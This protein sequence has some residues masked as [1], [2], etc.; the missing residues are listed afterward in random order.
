MH[1]LCTCLTQ[2]EHVMNEKRILQMCYH[3]FIMRLIG[4]FQDDRELYMLLELSLG[5]ELFSLLR[6]VGSLHETSARFY[7]ACVCSAFVYLH[8]KKIVYRDLKP[9][10]LIFNA[11]GYIVVVDFGF[12]KHVPTRTWTLCGT[13]EYLP[14]EMLLQKGSTLS[15]DWW[16]FG[17]LIYE[18]TFGQP[19][20][21]S[22]EGDQ[23]EIY[24]QILENSPK[25]PRS[26]FSPAAKELISKLLVSEP[27]K[28][29]GSAKLGTRAISTHEYFGAINWEK[30]TSKELAAP[31]VPKIASPFDTSNFDDYGDEDVAAGEDPNDFIDPTGHQRLFE[32]WD[33]IKA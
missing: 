24:Q 30:L 13:P 17:V 23:M 25:Y 4:A 27:A 22:P 16:S 26:R 20:F 29:L 31:Y 21:Y 8:D 15:A 6:K 5:G 12:A 28:R 2:V 10:N 14:P 32:E 3:P 33:T 7:A 18:M 9:E 1:M 19:P 11:Q